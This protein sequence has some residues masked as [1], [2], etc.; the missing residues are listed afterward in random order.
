MPHRFALYYAP[1]INDPL[2]D[3]ATTWLGRDAAS[4][5]RV[6]GTVAGIDPDRL[7]NLTQSAARYGFHATIKP[8]MALAEGCSEAQLRASLEEFCAGAAPVDL[9]RLRIANLDGFLA[10]V[11]QEDNPILQDFAAHVVVHFEPFRAPL[12]A[13]RRAARAAAG[14]TERQLELLDAYG[15][16]Y[17]LEQFRFHMT[18]TDRLNSE[19]R[20][21]V[22]D[23]ARIWFEP[24]LSRP[25]ILDRLVLYCEPDSGKPFR[26][27]AEFSLGASA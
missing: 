21:D 4:G 16:P 12:D 15:Y 13:A 10:L 14:L 18:L 26:R 20:G 2:W 8:P 23:A 19:D 11:P 9:G 22:P 1:D 5:A 3:R 24:V 6:D 7:L 25:V 17:V 27:I